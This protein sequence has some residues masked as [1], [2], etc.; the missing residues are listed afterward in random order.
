MRFCYP[1]LFHPARD[2]LRIEPLILAGQIG[3]GDAGRFQ[4][5]HEFGDAPV[6]FDRVIEQRMHRL[7]ERI[8]EIEERIG[9]DAGPPS[10]SR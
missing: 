4:P 7:G 5:A 6:G 2:A 3:Q 8:V 10:T 9:R 1:G